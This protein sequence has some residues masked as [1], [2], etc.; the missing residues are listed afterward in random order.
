MSNHLKRITI[1][2]TIRLPR[3]S[4]KWI[5]RPATATHK[6]SN[7]VSINTLL[8][9]FLGVTK[10]TKETKFILNQGKVLIDGIA[11]KD[12]KFP[13]GLMDTVSIETINKHYRI[14][15]DE[16]GKLIAVPISAEDAK[17]KPRKI[18]NKVTMRGNKIQVNLNDGY[19]LIDSGKDYKVNDTLLFDLS[20]K[21]VKS[22]LKLEKGATVYIADGNKK[23]M[24]GQI[25]E[26][27]DIKGL[28]PNTI[29]FTKDNT[30]FKT[31]KEYAIVIGKTKSE[32]GLTQ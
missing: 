23:G 17:I 3:K 10:T 11:R 22:H 30:E 9:E 13:V 21:K 28:Q 5:T 8:K 12:Y 19:N 4:T 18:V 6:V 7:A 29:T 20:T 25:K 2:R 24:V 1:P 32:I 14:L 27:T 16:M 15:Y 26:I 31:K